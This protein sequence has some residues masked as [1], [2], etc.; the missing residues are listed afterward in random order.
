MSLQ[1]NE[2]GGGGGAGGPSPGGNIQAYLQNLMIG[3]SA[4]QDADA[5]ED[6]AVV[7]NYAPFSEQSLPEG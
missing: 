4:S 5:L 1:G 3:G 7:S 2:G 6:R